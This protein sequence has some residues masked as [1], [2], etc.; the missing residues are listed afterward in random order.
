MLTLLQLVLA[1]APQ[2][3]GQKATAAGEALCAEDA[4]CEGNACYATAHCSAVA[5]A[6]FQAPRGAPTLF[7]HATRPSDGEG[8]LDQD[9][10]YSWT[11]TELVKL[12][13]VDSDSGGDGPHTST[14]S[15]LVVCKAQSNGVQ[16]LDVRIEKV[17]T[18]SPTT[19]DGEWKSTTSNEV[20]HYVWNG[21]AF[22]V[23][24]VDKPCARKPSPPVWFKSASASSTLVEK[25][26]PAAYYAPGNAADGLSETAWAEKAKGPGL[27]EWLELQ[28]VRPLIISRVTLLGG[29]GTTEKLWR[30]NERLKAVTL[31]FSDGEPE[32]V[33]L[34][35]K[36]I[37]DPEQVR[38]KRTAPTSSL[39]IVVDEVYKAKFEDAC[40][41]E[42]EL[43]GYLP[44][45]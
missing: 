41:S 33:S 44:P 31:V 4:K 6:P 37:G 17:V 36:S 29:C 2:S 26:L 8:N 14:S 10:Y 12:L 11:G 9:R 23:E 28:L 16:E 3:A 20:R 15:T 24:L 34:K 22:D 25:G 43:D 21:K 45:H 30:A 7:L 27:G 39:R 42:V 19:P 35:D 38:L 5:D 1:A 32:K 18:D 40:I 13:D